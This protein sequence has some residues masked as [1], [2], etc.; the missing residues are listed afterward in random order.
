MHL[1]RASRAVAGRLHWGGRGDRVALNFPLPGRGL[2]A[3]L[4]WERLGKGG[5]GLGQGVWRKGTGMEGG[6]CVGKS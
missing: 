4:R 5:S 3:G 2:G 6:K 1:S